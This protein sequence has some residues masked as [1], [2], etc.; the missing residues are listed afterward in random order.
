MKFSP[1][2]LRLTVGK[3]PVNPTVSL[4][5]HFASSSEITSLLN[6]H[7]AWWNS[8]WS[9]SCVSLPTSDPFPLLQKY[10]YGAQYLLGISSRAGKIPPGLIKHLKRL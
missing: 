9:A 7:D 10:W 8:Y 5:R 6:A 2:L 3:D 4:V 1:K